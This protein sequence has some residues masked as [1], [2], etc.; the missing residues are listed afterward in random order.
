MIGRR[1]G[2]WVCIAMAA[3]ACSN[4]PYPDSDDASSV[5]YCYLPSPPKTFDP[6]VSYTRLSHIVLVNCYETLLEYHAKEY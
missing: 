6:A 3:V 1:I 5:R 2:V 4:N